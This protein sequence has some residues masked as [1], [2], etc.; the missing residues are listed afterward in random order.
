MRPDRHGIQQ[1]LSSGQTIATIREETEAT[2]TSL[3]HRESRK[4]ARLSPITRTQPSATTWEVGDGL[5]RALGWLAT[6][7][8]V[9]IPARAG[10]MAPSR[11]FAG[12]CFTGGTFAGIC[13]TGGF[14]ASAM[15][16]PAKICLGVRKA[17]GP[18]L[19]G[20]DSSGPTLGNRKASETATGNCCW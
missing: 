9:G 6:C 15:T 16:I 10:K 5:P 7:A 4:L 17:S 14:P 3:N 11:A 1:T 12:I 13:F 8:L 19:G 18:T 20:C 2:G